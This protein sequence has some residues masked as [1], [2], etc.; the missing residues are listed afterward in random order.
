MFDFGTY[1]FSA[2][3]IDI[4]PELRGSN[5]QEV[6]PL[7]KITKCGVSVPQFFF[8]HSLI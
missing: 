5:Q 2:Q 7:V 6:L 4:N 1:A 8:V 3:Y